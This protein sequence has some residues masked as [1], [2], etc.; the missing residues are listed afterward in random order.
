[1]ADQ[2]MNPRGI[3]RYEDKPIAGRLSDLD[4]KVLG[5]VD[6]SKQNADVF[7]EHVLKVLSETYGF[8]DILRIK[9]ASGSVP[10]P[11]SPEFFERCHLVIN[12]FGD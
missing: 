4:K 7:L 12:A 3:S 8:A 2:L 6:N 10:A 9:K 11:L 1:M 5:L